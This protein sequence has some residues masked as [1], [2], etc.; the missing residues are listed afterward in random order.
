M[1]F[2]DTLLGRKGQTPTVD[3]RAQQFGDEWMQ[4][5]KRFGIVTG[6]GAIN[7]DLEAPENRC[8]DDPA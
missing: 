7:L 8:G 3:A 4:A 6:L 1:G 2:L 5:V